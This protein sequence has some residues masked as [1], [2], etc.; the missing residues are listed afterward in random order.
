[1]YIS[2]FCWCSQIHYKVPVPVTDSHAQKMVDAGCEDLKIV[3]HDGRFC[4][5]SY[6]VWYPKQDGIMPLEND[7]IPIVE[8]ITLLADMNVYQKCFQLDGI[9][10]K[11]KQAVSKYELISC[12]NRMMIS[13]GGLLGDYSI[14]LRVKSL[15]LQE[16]IPTIH[17]LCIEKLIWGGSSSWEC[18]PDVLVTS[19]N[20]NKLK[21]FTYSGTT[22]DSRNLEPYKTA[23]S[24]LETLR[25]DGSS[26]EYDIEKFLYVLPKKLVAI[27]LDQCGDETNDIEAVS[28]FAKRTNNIYLPEW[29]T[30]FDAL[31]SRLSVTAV[32]HVRKSLVHGKKDMVLTK[33][34]NEYISNLITLHGDTLGNDFNVL[35]QLYHHF[36]YIFKIRAGRMR[37]NKIGGSHF[38]I[39]EFL[40]ISRLFK[41]ESHLQIRSDGVGFVSIV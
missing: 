9:K 8:P 22:L 21:H 16:D 13:I 24:G 5:A 10:F 2:P 25:Y 29:E 34:C 19:L 32:L 37:E 30:K 4:L 3:L 33:I 40:W 12:L 39:L 41:N 28:L 31:L 38:A 26:Y 35:I 15:N 1:M 17:L 6:T 36:T 27:E 20:P 23:F 7:I 11:Q 14:V 18:R